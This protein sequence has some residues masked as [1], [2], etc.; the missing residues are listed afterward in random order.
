MK[1][2]DFVMKAGTVYKQNGESTAADLESSL[3]K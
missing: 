3:G 1:K 2:V